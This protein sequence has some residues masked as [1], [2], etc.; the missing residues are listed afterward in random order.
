MDLG[1]G[2]IVTISL[3]VVG[4]VV[5]LSMFISSVFSVSNRTVKIIERFGK[6]QRTAGAGLNFKIPFIDTVRQTLSL[7]VEQHI[8]PVD[9]ITKDKVSVRVSCTVNYNVLEGREADSYYKLATPKAQ[10][11]TFVFD[12]VRSQVPKL[13]LDEIFDSKDHIAQA[14]KAELTSDMAGFGY[15]IGK[16]LVTEI[17]PDAKVKAAMNEIN[18]AQREAQAANARGEAE[19]TLRVKQAEAQMEA[20]RL[21]G[22][23]IAQ[24][25]LAIINGAKQSV[26]ELKCAYPGVSEETHM[27]MLMMTQYFETLSQLGNKPGDKVIFVPGTPDGVAGFRQQIMEGLAATPVRTSLAK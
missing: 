13:T 9:S 16:V 15:E 4:G 27:N 23:G 10:I 18:A 14:V 17:E 3:L 11:E 12:V 26:E 19:K 6:Y 20:D 7:Q 25:R 5:L 2:S 22:E 24:Q 21:K 1:I 8:I